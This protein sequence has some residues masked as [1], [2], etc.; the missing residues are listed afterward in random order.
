M[1]QRCYNKNCGNYKRYG[2]RGISV[3]E[4]WHTFENFLADMGDRPTGKTLDRYPDNDGNYEPGNCRWATRNEQNNNKRTSRFIEHDGRRKTIQ[5][6]SVELG[7]TQETIVWRLNAGLPIDKVLSRDRF[8]PPQ[9]HLTR[10][11]VTKR[12][13][14]WARELGFTPNGLRYRLKIMSQEMALKPKDGSHGWIC[15]KA[16]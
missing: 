13:A 4:R 5:Q 12:L 6:W 8:S 14:E 11:G 10:N 1:F 15:R 16:K 9:K 7:L 2:G 3:C